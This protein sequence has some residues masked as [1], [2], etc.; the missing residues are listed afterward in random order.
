MAIYYA[1]NA[2]QSIAD[3]KFFKE[4]AIVLRATWIIIKAIARVIYFMIGITFGA[5]V[6]ITV[7]II[8]LALYTS[9]R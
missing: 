8:V 5:A 3:I 9:I 1:A 2:I 7:L 4:V 6:P